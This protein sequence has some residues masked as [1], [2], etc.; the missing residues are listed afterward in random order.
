MKGSSKND[1]CYF[2]YYS[3]C[4]KSDR[5]PFRH[6]AAALGNE[7]V[8]SY[9]QQGM[10][11]KLHCPFRHMEL[12]K[13]R[14]QIPCYWESQPVGC[15][16]SHCPFFHKTLKELG[17]ASPN[18]DETLIRRV[19]NELE[20]DPE[21]GS[22]TPPPLVQ[23]MVVSINEESDTESIPSPSKAQKNT[24]DVFKIKSLEELKLEQI[25]KH[26]AAMYQYDQPAEG[27]TKTAKVRADLRNRLQ[28]SQPPEQ[29]QNS[30]FKVKT[31]EE[32]RAEK[33]A[34]NQVPKDDPTTM[35]ELTGSSFNSKRPAPQTKKQIRIKRP[36]ISADPPSDVQVPN[37][38]TEN[39]VTI[40]TAPS[41]LV[42]GSQPQSTQAEDYLDD[43]D[44]GADNNTGLLN[45]DELLLEIDNILGD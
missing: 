19:K 36:K 30:E 17:D 41:K 12:K 7:T 6:E 35:E 23:S 25:Q 16:K 10:C 28:V 24:D 14:S 43:D 37:T 32:I 20:S 34:K 13:N 27:K 45:E 1:D 22:T 39:A 9:W 15:Q 4:T 21:N 18:K 8:C 44:D 33:L 40:A 31:L 29:N 42:E 3:S 2:F 5:C 38:V 26:D 11:S